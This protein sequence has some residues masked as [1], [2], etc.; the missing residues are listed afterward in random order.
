MSTHFMN[1]ELI[2]DNDHGIGAVNRELIH[3][4]AKD[5]AILSGRIPPEMT[6][7][8]FEQAERELEGDWSSILSGK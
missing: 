6:K 7:A 8:D 3:R 5:L 1:K 4:R 2:V